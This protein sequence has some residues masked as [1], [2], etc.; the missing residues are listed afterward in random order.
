[1]QNFIL[2]QHLLQEQMPRTPD[3]VERKRLH[4]IETMDCEKAR[5]QLKLENGQ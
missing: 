4:I 5:K 3:A 1:M 2:N